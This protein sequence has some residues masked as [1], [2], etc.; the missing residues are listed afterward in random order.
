MS[1]Y[2]LNTSVPSEIPDEVWTLTGQAMTVLGE[3]IIMLVQAGAVTVIGE[4]GELV[5]G[6]LLRETMLGMGAQVVAPDTSVFEAPPVDGWSARFDRG[7][8]LD[9]VAPTGE[10]MYGGTL[11]SWGDWRERLRAV[12]RERGG[13][14]VVT[15]PRGTLDDFGPAIMEGRACWVRV[16]LVDAGDPAVHERALELR[17]R[18][19][20]AMDADSRLDPQLDHPDSDAELV[21]L[22]SALNDYL[23]LHREVLGDHPTWVSW[24]ADRDQAAA[25]QPR[26][27]SAGEQLTDEPP[28]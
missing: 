8:G 7:V 9:L 22:E 15:G 13:V 20:A 4:Q 5:A 16:R 25:R 21:R 2:F 1:Y 19:F 6:D 26:P 27:R 28:F 10:T 23:D 17:R 12:A 3:P 11:D 24:Y 14:V 18:F